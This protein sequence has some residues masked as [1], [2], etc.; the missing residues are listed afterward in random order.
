MRKYLLLLLSAIFAWSPAA[1]AAESDKLSSEEFLEVMRR[2]RGLETW[3]RMS[4]RIDHARSDGRKASAGVYLATL[5][6]ADRMMSQVIVDERQGYLIGQS[7]DDATSGTTVTPLH[8][9]PGKDGDLLGDFGLR[10]EDLAMSFIYWDFVREL[11]R[12][13]IT[14]RTCRVF[15]L[16]KNDEYV[17]L[18]VNADYLFPMRVSWYKGGFDAKSTPYRTLEAT[19]FKEVNNL[20]L[21]TRLQLEGPGWRTRVDFTEANAGHRSDLPENLFRSGLK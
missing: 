17:R 16:R 8:K 1:F 20:W 12:E 7:F 15:L 9:N 4:G 11:E 3:G 21:V 6:A 13:T 14:F 5:F 18:S 19:K 10:A 2:P